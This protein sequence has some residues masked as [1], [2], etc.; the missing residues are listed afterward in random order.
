MN[1][2][3]D[4]NDYNGINCNNVQ[5]KKKLQNHINFIQAR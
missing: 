5:K 2:I 3:Q 4:T 1:E